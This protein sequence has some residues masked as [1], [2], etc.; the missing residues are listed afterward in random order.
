MTCHDSRW[1]GLPATALLDALLERPPH[2]QEDDVGVVLVDEF[3]RLQ[4]GALGLATRAAE[5]VL[6]LSDELSHG[7]ER[8]H[9]GGKE[10]EVDA[11][12]KGFGVVD[13]GRGEVDVGPPPGWAWA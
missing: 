1:P 4:V 5:A 6:A 12:P 11:L 10:H 13:V 8:G 2:E 3:L 9:G 7:E